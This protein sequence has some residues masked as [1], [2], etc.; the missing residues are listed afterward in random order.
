MSLGWGFA[1]IPCPVPP[2]MFRR[3]NRC[4]SS[5]RALLGLA[6]AMVLHT[7]HAQATIF[8]Q[9]EPA[10]DGSRLLLQTSLYT[11]HFRP[12]PRHNNHQRLVDIEYWRADGWL[13]G[14]AWFSN[15][16]RQPTQYVFGGYRWR[17]FDERPEVYLKL[18][19]GLLHGYAGEFRDK[20]PFNGSGIAPALVPALGWSTSRFN[21]EIVLFGTAGLMITTGIFLP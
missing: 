17:P 12:D 14:F 2:W 9:P 11:R 20:I 8:T 18:S 6:V 5:V 4:T 15:S 10:E 19:G 7:A 1:E 16:F 13:L 21:A 3:M